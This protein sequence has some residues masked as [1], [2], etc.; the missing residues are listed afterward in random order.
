[1]NVSKKSTVK[2]FRMVVVF[3]VEMRGVG[4]LIEVNI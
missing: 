1:M 3:G 4:N 2:V